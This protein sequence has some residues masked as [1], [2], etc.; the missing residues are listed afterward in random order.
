MPLGRRNITFTLYYIADY[1]AKQTVKDAATL[2]SRGHDLCSLLPINQ[3]GSFPLVYGRPLLA[4]WVCRVK[5]QSSENPSFPLSMGTGSCI[6]VYGSGILKALALSTS[7][8]NP[9]HALK[10]HSLR[11]D[12]LY[13]LHEMIVYIRDNVPY[14]KKLG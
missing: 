6:H 13:I 1:S 2:K 10:S 9:Q 12:F 14:V 7:V 3:I 11:C 8:S 4:I 5:L